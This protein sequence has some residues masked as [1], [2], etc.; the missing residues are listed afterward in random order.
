M[1]NPEHVFV[2]PHSPVTPEICN[3]TSRALPALALAISWG[4]MTSVLLHHLPWEQL[5]SEQLFFEAPDNVACSTPPGTIPTF[6]EVQKDPVHQCQ[7]QVLSKKAI[8]K[9]FCLS[10]NQNQSQQISKHFQFS[11]WKQCHSFLP[12]THTQKHLSLSSCSILLVCPQITSFPFS[13]QW[14]KNKIKHSVRFDPKHFFLSRNQ[15]TTTLAMLLLISVS[16]LHTQIYYTW[17]YRRNS[18]PYL[19]ICSLSAL[20]MMHSHM[21]M[22]FGKA[23]E[24]GQGTR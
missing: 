8:P 4:N 10:L 12:S 18:S 17:E 11:L 16:G 2:Y 3:A 22:P 21:D 9:R 1:G 20:G 24:R 13:L 7:L 15:S 19:S 5:S 14:K 6:S 23:A